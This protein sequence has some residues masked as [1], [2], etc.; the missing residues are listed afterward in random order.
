VDGSPPGLST[1]LIHYGIPIVLAVVLFGV[2]GPIA[3]ILALG[4]TLWNIRDKNRQGV[5]DKL[6]KTFVV[7]A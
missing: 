7:E 4:S 2:L 3:V 5:N 1:S 6:G